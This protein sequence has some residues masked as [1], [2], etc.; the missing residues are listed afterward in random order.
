M[1]YS[2]R[3]HP[4]EWKLQPEE[5]KSFDEQIFGFP[6]REM[7]SLF[8]QAHFSIERNDNDFTK[9]AKKIVLNAIAE[10]QGAVE[11]VSQ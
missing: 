8:S 6:P 9:S 7:T 10:I 2:P 1:H 3:P 5:V 11:T 4:P